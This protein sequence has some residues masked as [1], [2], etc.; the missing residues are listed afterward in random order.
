MFQVVNRCFQI[1]QTRTE[2]SWRSHSDVVIEPNVSGVEWDGFQSGPDLVR[3]GETAALAALPKIQALLPKRE[4]AP[5]QI[6]PV[7]DSMPA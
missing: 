7:P 6:S 5:P 3:A 2:D 4:P 1:L